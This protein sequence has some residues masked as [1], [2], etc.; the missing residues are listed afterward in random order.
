MS[1]YN[2]VSQMPSHG[3]ATNARVANAR[4]GFQRGGMNGMPVGMGGGRSQ[5]PSCPFGPPPPGRVYCHPAAFT[6]L[7][8]RKYIPMSQAYGNSVPAQAYY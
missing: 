3:N 8:G 4:E 1:Q 6:D 7:Y 2:P 5:Q